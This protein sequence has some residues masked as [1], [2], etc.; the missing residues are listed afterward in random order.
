MAKAAAQLRVS[1]PT[2]S[3]VIAELEHT[4][5][6]RLL[7]RSPQGVQP[8]MYGNALLKRSI[9]VFDGRYSCVSRAMACSVAIFASVMRRASSAENVHSHPG[10]HS[11]RR[12]GRCP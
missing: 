11:E 8:T 5:G 7:D 2:V 10:G 4:F 3:E 9:A 1:Q 6:M 12:A